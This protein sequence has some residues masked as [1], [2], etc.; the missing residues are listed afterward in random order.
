MYASIVVA[1]DIA[2]LDRG[3]QIL[4]KAVALLDQGG[5]I[6]LVNVVEELPSYLA[7]DV[8]TDLLGSARQEAMTKLQD[9]RERVGPQ[10]A[11]M[12]A[13]AHRPTKFWPPRRLIAQ[14]SSCLPRTSRTS[15]T[16]HRCDGGPRRA[17]CQVLGSR[18][19]LIRRPLMDTQHYQ[20]VLEARRN[21]LDRRLHKIEADLDQPGNR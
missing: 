5:K 10:P 13:R 18:R 16:S 14:I 20:Q 1:I 15:P 21:E 4:K 3:E 17:P 11:S 8:P 19:P 6:A 9:L 12:C 2:Q 7:I